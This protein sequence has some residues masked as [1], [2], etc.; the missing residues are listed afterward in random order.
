MGE[1]L[2]SRA[3][4]ISHRGSGRKRSATRPQGQY[5]A[6]P[7]RVVGPDQLE[8]GGGRDARR[9]GQA[10]GAAEARP[11]GVRH[12]LAVQL[13]PERAFA[14]VVEAQRAPEE[15]VPAE[16]AAERLDR[17]LAEQVEPGRRAPEQGAAGALRGHVAQRGEERRRRQEVRGRPP[18]R[19]ELDADLGEAGRE[20]DARVGEV[21]RV[22]VHRAGERGVEPAS[23]PARPRRRPARRRRR[24]PSAASG[25]T[26]APSSPPAPRAARSARRRPSRSRAAGSRSPPASP[27]KT[28]TLVPQGA[29][30]VRSSPSTWTGR[31]A[32]AVTIMRPARASK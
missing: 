15:Q 32:P 21:H 25:G 20:R 16:L 30:A 5:G 18:V 4:A 31:I 1:A 22:E 11:R 10:R 3:P 2:A 24:R 26:R 9:D 7:A 19:E 6:A 27:P 13:Q 14:L 12:A 29:R 17:A 28:S 23:S 8:L